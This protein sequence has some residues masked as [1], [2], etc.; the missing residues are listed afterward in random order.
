MFKKQSPKLS[1]KDWSQITSKHWIKVLGKH[2]KDTN[3]VQKPL[4]NHKITIDS[5]TLNHPVHQTLHQIDPFST[6]FC[7]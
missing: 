5:H 4:D 1:Y 6:M 2:N 7:T 3:H